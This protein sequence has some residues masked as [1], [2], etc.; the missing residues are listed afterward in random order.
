MSFRFN[1][2]LVCYTSNA[3]IDGAEIP[4]LREKGLQ[5][6]SKNRPVRENAVTWSSVG[7]ARSRDMGFWSDALI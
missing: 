4:L 1:I 2:F 6:V 3:L 5:N 7:V